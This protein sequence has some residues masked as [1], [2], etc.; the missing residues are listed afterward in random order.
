[1][2]VAGDAFFY[3][4]TMDVVCG[5]GVQEGPMGDGAD[6]PRLNTNPCP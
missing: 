6:G 2:P 3:L 4:V 1:M 5:S